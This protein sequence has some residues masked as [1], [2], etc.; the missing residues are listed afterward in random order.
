MQTFWTPLIFS[1][2]LAYS[3]LGYKITH[4]ELPSPTSPAILYATEAKQDLQITFTQAIDEAKKS[5]HLAIYSLKDKK[6]IKALRR[7]GK[8]GVKVQIVC[9]HEASSGAAKKLGSQIETTYRKSKGLMHLK[10]LVVDRMIS[11][12]GSANL[13]TASLKMHANLVSGIRSKSLASHLVKKIKNLSREG[14]VKPLKRAE[15]SLPG[16]KIE[17]WT[18]PDNPRGEK[19]IKKL[20]QG[21]KK[22]VRVAMFTWTRFDL[23]DAII[24][25]RKRGLN[26]EVVLDRNSST[27]VS[28]KIAQRLL[29]A[30]IN[31]RVNQGQELLHHKCLI[32]D[33]KTLLNGSANWTKAAF[34]NNDDCF[35]IIS[36]LNSDQQL[37]L[38]KMWK[39]ML[40]NS[41]LL[42]K[43]I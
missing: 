1:V 29:N 3:W 18:F 43:E 39:E 14:L 25:A 23:A 20:I 40:Y 15:F 34:T 11:Y 10:L 2:I 4:T 31:V 9:D 12:C 33:D 22:S 24:A 32:I 26:V 17:M 6:I 16:Q 42:K 19:R 38:R 8:R 41:I 36:P 5:I 30:G 28:K 13:T 27:N 35:L 7:A 37:T 21:A